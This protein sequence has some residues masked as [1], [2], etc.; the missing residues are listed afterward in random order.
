MTHTF[1]ATPLMTA[2]MKLQRSDGSWVNS[3]ELVR[4]NDPIVATS[5]ALMAMAACRQAL[6]S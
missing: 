3:I 5:F 1:W 2:L 4:E 6:P